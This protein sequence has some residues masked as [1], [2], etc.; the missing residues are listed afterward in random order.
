L[1]IEATDGSPL[2]EPRKLTS[3]LG[4]TTFSLSPD[5]TQILAVKEQSTSH[6]WS[7]PISET[8]TADPSSGVQLTSGNVRDDR[9]R[10]SAD[11]TSIFFQSRRRGSLDIWRISDALTQPVRLTTGEG[12]ELR[13]RPSPHADWIAV[14]VDDATGE[15]T[16]LMRPDGSQLHVLHDRWSDTYAQVCCA[17]WSPNGSRLAVALE[18]REPGPVGTLAVA[19]IDRATGLATAMRVLTMLPGGAPQYGRWSPDGRLLAYEALTEGSWDLWMVDPDAPAPT[20]LTRYPGNDR[21]AVWQPDPL[22]LYFI[23]DQRE[24]WRI[25]FDAHGAPA[26]APVQWFVPP[27]RLRV[28]ADSLDINPAGDRLL[29]TL[30]ADAS[31]IWLVELR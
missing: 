10:W 29:L 6:L 17:D 24:I 15:F 26:G 25:P 11:G 5:G 14:D 31:D 4:A 8:T 23:R 30:L 28:A 16:H 27:G 2:G 1:A 20:R 13:P 9:G 7:Y 21:Q 19:S 12:S 3:A 22:Q 18:T